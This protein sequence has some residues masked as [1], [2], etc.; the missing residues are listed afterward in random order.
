MS[1]KSPTVRSAAR[2]ENTWSAVFA[3]KMSSS[4]V[5]RVAKLAP[6]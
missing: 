2:M 1:Q 4:W 5:Y 6:T 3:G